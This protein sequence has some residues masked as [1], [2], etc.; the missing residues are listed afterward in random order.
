MAERAKIRTE[1]TTLIG[2]MTASVQALP[3]NEN[4]VGLMVTMVTSGGWFSWTLPAVQT[5]DGASHYLGLGAYPFFIDQNCPQEALNVFL[6][7]AARAVITEIS[8]VD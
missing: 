5:A 7:V 3:I 8:R 4:R 6:P 1:T 2:P